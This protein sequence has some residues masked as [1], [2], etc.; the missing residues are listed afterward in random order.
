MDQ[1]KVTVTITTSFVDCPCTE[2]SVPQNMWCP[3]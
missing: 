2:P 1:A 3:E